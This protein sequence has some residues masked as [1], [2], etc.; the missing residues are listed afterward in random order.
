MSGWERGFLV[1]AVLVQQA[2]FIP[3]PEQLL[4]LEPP[5]DTLGNPIDPAR[6]NPSN[7]VLMLA[8]LVILGILSMARL[9]PLFATIKRN[10]LVAVTT[11]LVVASVL[12]SYDPMLSL[13]RAGTYWLGI[14]L[15]LYI[16]ERL[17]FDDVV[18][19]L[20]LST[21][22]PAFGSAIY[23]LVAPGLAYMQSP[24]VAGSLRG[25]YSHKNQLANVMA[26]G[27]MLQLYLALTTARWRWHLALAALQAFLVIEAHSASFT[28]SLGLF[29]LVLGIYRV[30]RFNWQFAVAGMLAGALLAVGLGLVAIRNPEAAFDLL[31]RDPTLTGRTVL[32]P[33]LLS[34]IAEHPWLGWGFSAFWQT[35]NDEMIRIW[36]QVDWNPPHAHNGFL[37]VA[38]DFGGVGVVLM[39]LMLAQFIFNAARLSRTDTGYE[40]WIY[41]SVIAY[42]LCNNMVEVSMLRSQEFAW[43][44]FLVFFMTCAARQRA[45]TRKVAAATP[46]IVARAK[47]LPRVA[48]DAA[49]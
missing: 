1:F 38:I 15:T 26:L 44:A 47:P 43:F 41:W 29:A 24:E 20:A 5:L 7:F 32:W 17:R 40:S 8:C 36:D 45:P 48:N 27:V 18:R 22:L 19:L 13:R 21:V 16:V 42:T 30:G 28:V 9:R 46:S 35:G 12:W 34:V 33:A 4:G 23:A 37:E 31:G 49:P 10:P 6:S 14:L 11:L 3:L 39:I 2:A 25:V